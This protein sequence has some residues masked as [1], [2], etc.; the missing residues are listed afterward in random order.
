MA[1]LTIDEI[2]NLKSRVKAEMARRCGYG[3]IDRFSGDEYD[4]SII[5]CNFSLVF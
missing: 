5:A 3:A 4:F 1:E 2:N